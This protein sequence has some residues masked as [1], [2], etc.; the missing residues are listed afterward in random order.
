MRKFSKG[1]IVIL[2]A[3]FS[4]WGLLTSE[5]RAWAVSGTGTATATIIRALTI[6]NSTSD[7]AFGQVERSAA[8]VVVAA[9]TGQTAT[10]GSFDIAGEGGK[11]YTITL[12]AVA[13][14]LTTGAGNTD[15]L[16]L[17]VDTFTSFPSGTGTLSGSSPGAGTESLYVGATLKGFAQEAISANQEY[18]AYTGTYS[19][20]VVY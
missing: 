18:G 12:P 16:K 13:A 9:D 2:V 4:V 1:I 8:A 5:Q 10:N 15:D 14:V 3:A 20:T 6:S 19:V 17:N 11:T 7:L